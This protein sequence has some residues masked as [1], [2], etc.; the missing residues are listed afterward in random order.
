MI[1]HQKF[2]HLAICSLIALPLFTTQSVLAQGRRVK[3]V[4]PRNLDTLRVSVPG[5]TRSACDDPG[6]CLIALLPDLKVQDA[7][8]PQTLAEHPTIYFLVPKVDGFAYFTL[9]EDN[10]TT[11]KRKRIYKTKFKIKNNAG[12]IAFRMPNDAPKLEI[13][14]KYSWQFSVPVSSY[15]SQIV[16]GSLRRVALDDKVTAKL[17]TTSNPLDRAAVLA[18][19]GIWFEAV[20]TLAEAQIALPKNGEVLSEWQELLKAANLDR[21]LP[22]TFVPQIRETTSKY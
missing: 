1:S 19:T 7:P 17:A 14:K 4:P 10:G 9:D 8:L 20:Q 22:F 2:M 11:N 21:V 5:A 12:L 3:Y 6:S 15:N 16:Y 18:S 13:N